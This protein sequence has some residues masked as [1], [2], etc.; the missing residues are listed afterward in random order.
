M[1]RGVLAAP[2][3]NVDPE[4]V[5][6]LRGAKRMHKNFLISLALRAQRLEQG[7]R[8]AQQQLIRLQWELAQLRTRGAPSLSRETEDY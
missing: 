6:L 7:L 3:R 2:A 4:I 8:T 1:I 5:A